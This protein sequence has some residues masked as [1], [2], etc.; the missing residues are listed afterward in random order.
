MKL[1]MLKKWGRFKKDASVTV[2]VPGTKNEGSCVDIKRA[3]QLVDD[4]FAEGTGAMKPQR[5]ARTKPKGGE[6]GR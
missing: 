4:G 5:P 2:L 6:R 3:Q 1:K